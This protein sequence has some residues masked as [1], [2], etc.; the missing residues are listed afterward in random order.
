MT[1]KETPIG[2]LRSYIFN[3]FEGYLK[4][5]AIK[6]YKEHNALLEVRNLIVE[7]VE[8]FLQEPAIKK[9]YGVPIDA[10]SLVSF[11]ESEEPANPNSSWLPTA[12][13]EGE[14]R[15]AGITNEE[16]MKY[17]ERLE[18]IFVKAG[19]RTSSLYMDVLSLFREAFLKPSQ[20]RPFQ[21]GTYVRLEFG[22]PTNESTKKQA[23]PCEICGENRTTDICHIIPNRLRG[24]KKVDNTLFLCPTHHGLFDRCMLSQDEW[25]R[26]DWSRMSQK[27]QSY[28][29][30]VLKVAHEKFWKKVES[31]I[32]RKHT[33]WGIGLYE[34]YDNIKK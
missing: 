27:A 1:S 16:F 19:T 12:D 14:K 2:R 21:S 24:T 3:L 10:L 31:G 25:D 18:R 13:P 23:I 11:S 9:K 32:Y 15:P 33:T 17:A 4:E 7:S 5:Y 8:K 26:I 29:H 28:A 20:N 22:V 6:D 30:K 34:L